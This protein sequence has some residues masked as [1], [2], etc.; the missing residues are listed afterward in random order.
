MNG[1]DVERELRDFFERTQTPEPSAR[2]RIATAAARLE[3]GPV[4]RGGP[5][6]ARLG[7]AL[8]GLAASIVLAA[9]VLLV[10]INDKR[11]TN[12]GPGG[13]V[14][15]SAHMS[16]PSIQ[17]PA[18]SPSSSDTPAPNRSSTDTPAPLVSMGPPH[19]FTAAG[20]MDAVYTLSA[21]LPD[22][23]VLVTGDST[24]TRPLGAELFDPATG[25]F[26]TTGYSNSMHEGG[27][28]TTLADGRVLVAGGYDAFNMT[29]TQV[30]MPPTNVAEIYDPRT[31][32]FSATGS[33]AAKQS[34]QVA[35]LLRD[36]RVLVV[37]GETGDGAPA[38]AELYEPSSGAFRPIGGPATARYGC[39]ATLL[40]D[41]RVLIAGGWAA[42]PANSGTAESLTSAEVF[43]PA[44]GIFTPVGSMAYRHSFG[45]LTL[46]QDGRVL[47]I[48]G[49]V[50]AELFDP[51]TDKF[52]P[53]GSMSVAREGPTATLLRDGRVL[54]AGG[55]VNLASTKFQDLAS[56]EIYD[57]KTGKFSATG[58]MSEPFLGAT[59]TLLE[60]GR[61]LI[62]GGGSTQ[63]YRP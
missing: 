11:A 24:G 12:A 54:V 53:T 29:P 8:I 36:G 9:G 60:D 57:P 17:S 41:G 35:V 4:R 1:S 28:A 21:L 49:E 56:A 33:L 26:S 23:R 25:R 63:L 32:T 38:S 2:L 22:G 51:A 13:G 62:A 27:T 55:S 59:A 61:V 48:G 16:S 6:D 39:S 3:A 31:G 15:P 14:S 45:T 40:S 30:A 46:L 37:G 43:D 7:L 50:E 42:G 5:R 10:V 34:G 20:P 44:S 18:P 47:A 52:S 19:A 58:S